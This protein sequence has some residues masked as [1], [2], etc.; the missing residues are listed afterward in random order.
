MLQLLLTWLADLNVNTEID[1][2]AHH[3]LTATEAVARFSPDAFAVHASPD[4][5]EPLL[6][7]WA[8]YGVHW[9]ARMAAIRLLG[10]LRRVTERGSRALRAAMNDVSFVQEAAYN[11]VSHFRIVEGDI[12]PELLRSIDDPSAGVAAAT[13]RLLMGVA[14]SEVTNADRRRILLTLEQ[15]AARMSMVRPDYL[16]DESNGVISVRYIDRLDRILY[17]AIVEVSGL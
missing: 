3:L 17:R 10:R 16:M 7:E 8:Q 2:Y 9:T 4:V 5:W 14:R 12:L 15:A 13:T 11:S 6:A 1:G